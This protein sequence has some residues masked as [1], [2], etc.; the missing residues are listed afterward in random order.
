MFVYTHS[1]AACMCFL[2][3]A[4]RVTNMQAES[5]PPVFLD[6]VLLQYWFHGPQ[7]P[8]DNQMN[9]SSSST[10]GT[11]R[12]SSGAAGEASS[13]QGGDAAMTALVAS[14]FKMTCSDATADFGES[15]HAPPP[16]TMALPAALRSFCTVLCNCCRQA[17]CMQRCF[18]ARHPC[19]GVCNAA[20]APAAT[21]ET[22]AGS[23][24]VS[25]TRHIHCKYH[26]V[27]FFFK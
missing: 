24:L 6:E 7:G 20:A 25:L 12:T 2:N 21:C 11:S 23:H 8:P 15:L 10:G 22:P 27:I 5:A 4:R 18:T 1:N 13:T 9:A 19:C 3:R 14:Q 17:T 26:R 16:S